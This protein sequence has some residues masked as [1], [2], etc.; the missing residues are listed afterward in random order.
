MENSGSQ[1][2]NPFLGVIPK[3]KGY[4]Y[5]T[6]IS[7]YL[8]VAWEGEI[9]ANFLAPLACP[10]TLGTTISKEIHQAERWRC[11]KLEVRLMCSIW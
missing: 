9:S 11:W 10:A 2:G 6:P 8:M 3:G 5:T 4:V 7:H 1:H